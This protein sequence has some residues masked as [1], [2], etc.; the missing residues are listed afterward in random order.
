MSDDKKP[1]TTEMMKAYITI[2]ERQVSQMTL[3]VN[4]LEELND[5]LEKVEGHFHNGFKSEITDHITDQVDSVMEKMEKTL[6]TLYIIKE[7]VQ[8]GAEADKELASRAFILT[9]EVKDKISTVRADV[10]ELKSAIKVDRVTNIIGWST[11][12]ITMI[13]IVLK[14]FGK[15]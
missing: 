8:K 4:T 14:L 6:T 12:I 1:V 3:V 15:L 5:K 7:H 9:N 2:L 13:T 10:A 11:F